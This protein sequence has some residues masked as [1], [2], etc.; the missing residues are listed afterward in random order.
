M[1]T[2]HTAELAATPPQPWRNG[3]GTT[4]ELL[5][6]PPGAPAWLLRISVA[7]ID[8]DGPFSR[9]EGVQRWF[10]VL[11]GAGVVL[12]RPG[13][14]VSLTPTS[15][16]LGFDGADA[17]GCQLINGPTRDL[18]LMALAGAGRTGMARVV[19][20]QALV[21]AHRWRGLYTAVAAQLHTGPGPALALPAHSLAWADEDLAPA[22]HC[23]STTAATPLPAWWLTL[24]TTP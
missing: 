21:G 14:P 1:T 11:D 16:P 6:W 18:N 19:A 12:Q 10:S 20:G 22:W 24:D 17:P 9:F 8:A 5:A 2:M 7:R 15:A 3:G 13:G 23:T 4:Q